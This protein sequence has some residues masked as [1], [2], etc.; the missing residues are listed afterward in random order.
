VAVFIGSQCIFYRSGYKIYSKTP[1]LIL[2]FQSLID[3]MYHLSLK[4]KF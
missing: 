1:S 4:I 2:V 3:P